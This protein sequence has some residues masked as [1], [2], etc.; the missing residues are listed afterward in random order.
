[1]T[2]TAQ[3]HAL[4]VTLGATNHSSSERENNDYYATDP[5]ALELLLGVEQFSDKVWECACGAGHLSKVLVDHGYN[6]ISTD[7]IDRGYGV[8]G[9]DFLTTETQ[10]DGDIITNPPYKYAKEF[11]EHAIE[12]ITD[13]HRVA[14]FLKLQFLEG[15]ARRGLFDKYPPQY[16]YVASGRI[17]CCKNGVFTKQQRENNSAQAYAWFI[18]KKPFEGETIVRWFN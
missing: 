14:M 12:T 6:V 16:I 8:S 2:G 5:I 7:L 10:F 9:V 4:F 13:G 17:N 3:Q 18:W 15:K 1:M 11:A